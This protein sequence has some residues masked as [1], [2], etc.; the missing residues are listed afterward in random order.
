MSNNGSAYYKAEKDLQKQQQQQLQQQSYSYGSDDLDPKMP[1]TYVN[2]SGDSN[3]IGR[4]QEEENDN[5]TDIDKAN[6]NKLDSDELNT[7]SGR[8][9]EEK[10]KSLRVS[11]NTKDDIIT[12]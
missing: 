7:I 9:N 5:N 6:E 12:L 8:L 2:N 10:D 4:S 11:I 1:K 3:Q